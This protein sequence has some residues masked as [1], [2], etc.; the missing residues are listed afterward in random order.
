MS[1]HIDGTIKIPSK[2]CMSKHID[3]TTKIPSKACMSKHI[4]SPL[5]PIIAAPPISREAAIPFNS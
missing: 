2:A 4:D 3:G 1:K 5:S